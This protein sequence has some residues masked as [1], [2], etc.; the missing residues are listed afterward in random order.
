MKLTKL[1]F[2]ALVAL[3]AMGAKGAESAAADTLRLSREKCIEIA[4]SGSPT[5]RVADMEI[6]KTDYSKRETLAKLFPSIDFSG[7]YQRA[8]ELQTISMNMG[9]QSQRFKMGTDNV[10]NFGV[11]AQMPLVNLA[12]WKSI[13]LSDQQI[14]ASLESARG[15]RLD[16]VDN[17][18]KAYY[19][20]M[21]A[22]ASRKVIKANYDVAVKNA[23]V[24]KKQF[25]QGT[26]S[27]YD[28][29]RS[30][31]QVKNIEPELLQADIAVKQ[32]LLQLKVLM[33]L[34]MALDIYPATTLEEM[35]GQL[36]TVAPERHPS[37]AENTSLKALDIQ[38]ETLRQSI[39]IKKAA[40]VPSLSLQYNM[41]WNSMS[42]GSPFKA[43]QFNP[44]STVAV[45]LSIPIFSGGSKYYGLK[46][47]QIQHSEV[48]LQ[49]EN[50]VNSLQMQVDLAV[51]NIN[52]EVKQI[53]S[54]EE[55][56]RQAAKALQIMQKSFEIGGAS[57]LNLLDAELANTQAQLAHLQT[58]YNYLVSTSELHKLLGH[59]YTPA[60]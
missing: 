33:G 38:A 48:M 47:A 3:T 29:L 50:L 9:G 7:A 28:V 27:D 24:F 36:H 52:K 1:L 60:N 12:L 11:T 31:V 55:G 4:L 40:W 44:Y 42:N 56:V 51:D 26:A 22:I 45:A 17:V 54:S 16:M 49:R 20:A 37:F 13:K 30:S 58:I 41:N 10:V 18:N 19:A 35:Q 34:D 5:V 57:Y 2:A 6:K 46:Q 32:C 25:E 53:A 8:I 15:S 39:G 21:L 23:E 14:L 59:D 43:Q